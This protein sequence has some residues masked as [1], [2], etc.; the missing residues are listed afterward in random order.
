MCGG[1]AS[2]LD[3]P[4]FEAAL[5]HWCEV[6]TPKLFVRFMSNSV[7]SRL[8]SPGFEAALERWCELLSNDG[9]SDHACFAVIFA[10]GSFVMRITD[11]QGFEERIIEQFDQLGHSPSALRTF[12][13]LPEPGLIPAAPGKLHLGAGLVNDEVS[14]SFFFL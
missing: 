13:G 5:E 9:D 4:S 12:I 8:G 2:R 10:Q 11:R 6:L 7:A 1:V 3:K 14:A